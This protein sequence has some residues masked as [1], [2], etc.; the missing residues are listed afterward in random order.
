MSKKNKQNQAKELLKKYSFVLI[1]LGAV[2]THFVI[3]GMD[4]KDNDRIGYV[5]IMWLAASAIVF[6]MILYHFNKNYR[7]GWNDFNKGEMDIA[8]LTGEKS[9]KRVYIE[10]D[11][12]ATNAVVERISKYIVGQNFAAK[13]LYRMITYSF[14][15]KSGNKFTKTKK[16]NDQALHNILKV[17][18]YI[19]ILYDESNP[20]DSVI[21]HEEVNSKVKWHQLQQK[22]F[23][24]TIVNNTK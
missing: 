19:K 4:L 11:G 18:D 14:F 17:G 13:A 20:A 6:N 10:K 7:D 23:T 22:K 21:F 12:V 9:D 1:I 15:D 2:A 5:L 8:A 16:Y 3:N 24:I